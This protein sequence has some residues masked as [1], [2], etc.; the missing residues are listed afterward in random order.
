MIL[1]ALVPGDAFRQT[2]EIEKRGG[3]RARREQGHS[4]P[5]KVSS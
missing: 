5:P 4:A 3:L 1:I 2:E